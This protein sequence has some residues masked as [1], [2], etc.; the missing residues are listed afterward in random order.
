M[1][2]IVIDLDGTIIKSEIAIEKIF[3]KLLSKYNFLKLNPDWKD[4][5]SKGG[6]YLIKKAFGSSVKNKAKILKEFREEYKKVKHTKS[7]LY[8]GVLKFLKFFKKNNIKV[9]LC[10]NK[11]S[12]LVRKIL[13]DLKINSFFCKIWCRDQLSL[14]K[15]S[16]KLANYIKNYFK[17]LN[18]EKYMIIG[19]S[20]VDIKLSNF[21][22]KDCVL[23]VFK[24]GYLINDKRIDNYHL[25]TYSD[26]NF[27][28]IK[29]IINE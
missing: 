14:K 18:I 3:N 2:G 17:G 10:T 12:Y 20:E 27:R 9:F 25:F 13:N 29:L 1:R 21:F 23:W 24:N 19:D 6:I 4:G 7:D 5:I 15:P 28:K 26:F 11:P 8:C 22:G 16:L